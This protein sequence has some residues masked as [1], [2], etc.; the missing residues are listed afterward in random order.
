MSN[1]SNPKVECSKGKSFNDK[2][3]MNSLLSDLKSM[4][5]NYAVALTEASNNHLVEIYKKLFIEALALQRETY[6][7]MFR[8]GWYVLESAPKNNSKFRQMSGLSDEEKMGRT[9]VKLIY[10]LDRPK[11][12]TNYQINISDKMV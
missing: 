3:Y 4:T 2:D 8:N 12:K 11:Y 1:I 7:L 6:E 9:D 5:K 10:S